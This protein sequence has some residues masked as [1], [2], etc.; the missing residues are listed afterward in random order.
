MDAK[1]MVAT[2]RG[3]VK[4]LKDLLNQ[5]D[6]MAMVVVTATSKKPPGEDQPPAGNIIN[7]LLLASARGGSWEALNLL[8]EREDA[9][10][11]QMMVPTRKFLQ[12]IARSSSAQGRI[13]VSA[14]G[15]VEEGVDDQPVSSVAAGALLKGLTPQ[16]DT[17][18]HVVTNGGGRNFLKYAGI[19]C[20]RDKRILF[21][22]NHNGD[23]P[24]HRAARVGQPRMVSYLIHLAAREG[25]DTKLRFLRMEN[26]RH[27]TALHQAVRFEYG[28]GLR[29]E[30][31]EAFIGAA[32]PAREEKN[33]RDEI[34]GV[35][36]EDG[37]SLGDAEGTPE[38]RNIVK[39]LMGADA[40]LA[41]YPADGVSP[42]YL[43]IL[44]GKST[45]ALILY[46][47]SRGNLSHSGA[48][49]QNALHVAVLRDRVMVEFLVHWNRS[50]TAQVDKDGSTPLHFASSVYFRTGSDLRFMF[51]RTLPWCRFVW[52]PW[53]KKIHDLVFNANPAALYQADKDGYFPIHV[54]AS[55]GLKDVVQFFF[56]DYPDSAGLCDAKGRTFL[57]VA[58]DKEEF[59]IV[60]Y[61]CRTPSLAWILNMQDNDGNTA[62]HLAIEAR[63]FK[64]FCALFGSRRVCLNRINNQ[65]ETLRDLAKS[66]VPHGISYIENPECK[67]HE[68]LWRAETS[69]VPFERIS[70]MK[71][72]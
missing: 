20:N 55:V 25:A 43:A 10:K 17:A 31:K 30:E 7:P 57:H 70:F 2:D 53:G 59:D 68:V 52:I 60:S 47:M 14:A 41:N 44:L 13:P 51:L 33:K 22:R 39:L 5:E 66:K 40:E 50:L 49:G 34:G 27:E 35:L 21:S 1:P 37:K 8:L 6:A 62:L 63:N 64:I 26:N 67:I 23:T 9:K 42:L 19:I 18:L 61:V 29:Y 69:T 56:N 58:V 72:T 54:A 65:G 15:D 38:E 3:D 46:H 16:G 12:L 4:K 24:L 36:N 71:D 45:I 48:D 32:D 28:R 11:P